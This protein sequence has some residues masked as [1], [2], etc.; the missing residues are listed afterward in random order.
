MLLLTLYRY[1]PDDIAEIAKSASVMFTFRSE[2]S[3]HCKI[4]GV[5]GYLQSIFSVVINDRKLLTKFAPL[6]FDELNIDALFDSGR[7][8]D[9]Q[10]KFSLP[11]PSQPVSILM[12]FSDTSSQ[13]LDQSSFACNSE[14]SLR[15][16]PIQVYDPPSTYLSSFNCSV[17]PN[18]K[19]GVEALFL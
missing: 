17:Q 10:I 16:I 12:Q 13:N 4:V 19:Y 2:Q 15:P 3:I 8:Y 5:I 18:S 14:S 9:I 6:I 1:I 11:S 7:H